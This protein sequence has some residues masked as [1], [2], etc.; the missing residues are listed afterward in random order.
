MGTFNFT[1]WVTPE[2]NTITPEENKI[3]LDRGTKAD[4][5]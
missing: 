2:K 5:S 4:G 3:A 1:R